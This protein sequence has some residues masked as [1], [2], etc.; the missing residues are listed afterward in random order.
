MDFVYSQENQ[1]YYTLLLFQ[2]SFDH[3]FELSLSIM[4]ALKGPKNLKK[5]HSQERL[6]KFWSEAPFVFITH[7]SNDD[8]VHNQNMK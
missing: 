6:S 7:S 4:S 2:V 1:K 5:S 3:Y 8:K